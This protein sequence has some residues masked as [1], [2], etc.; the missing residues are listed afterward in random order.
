MVPTSPSIGRP[1]RGHLIGRP[2]TL[3]A[4]I[5]NNSVSPTPSSS[6]RLAVERLSA[7]RA[8]PLDI[9]DTFESNDREARV[10]GICRTERQFFG[11]PYVFPPMTRRSNMPPPAEDVVH[12]SGGA[13]A[14]SRRRM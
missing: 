8:R 10:V 3:F 9:G 7:G 11:Y 12:H 1:S 5:S 2:R 4:A 13:E 14:D 6:T